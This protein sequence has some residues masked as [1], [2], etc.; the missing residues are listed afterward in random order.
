MRLPSRMSIL[1]AVPRT[2][3]SCPGACRHPRNVGQKIFPAFPPLA[4]RARG[5]SRP[6]RHLQTHVCLFAAEPLAWPWRRA[7]RWTRCRLRKGLLL[8]GTPLRATPPFLS[9]SRCSDSSPS[10]SRTS[11]QRRLSRRPL[12]LPSDHKGPPSAALCHSQ[13]LSRTPRRRWMTCSQPVTKTSGPAARQA[14]GGQSAG[15]FL[16]RSKSS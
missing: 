10:A 9:A 16:P 3:L 1:R 8:R 11:A 4:R 13:R 12:D 2:H 5:A 14:V 6:L 15:A 7:L